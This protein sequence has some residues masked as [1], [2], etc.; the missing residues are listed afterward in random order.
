M[1]TSNPN[2]T[3]LPYAHVLSGFVDNSN[4]GVDKC[5]AR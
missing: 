2:L 5:L 1:R 4:L 3:P